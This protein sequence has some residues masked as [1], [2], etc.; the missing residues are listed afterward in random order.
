MIIFIL[1]VYIAIDGSDSVLFSLRQ[2]NE[3]GFVFISRIINNKGRCPNG[4]YIYARFMSLGVDVKPD[5]GNVQMISSTFKPIEFTASEPIDD[6][7]TYRSI[8]SDGMFAPI[9]G[10]AVSPNCKRLVWQTFR[11]TPPKKAH[12][13]DWS[14]ITVGVP[15]M[16][17]FIGNIDGSDLKEITVADWNFQYP[18]F[19]VNTNKRDIILNGNYDDTG[20]YLSSFEAFDMNDNKKVKVLSE[21]DAV[22]AINP[23]TFETISVPFENLKKP[24]FKE[25]MDYLR[26]LED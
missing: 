19:W 8:I 18:S 16:R 14:L 5:D 25:I 3:N 22:L 7:I 2:A 21:T 26:S 15:D 24:E 17:T 6:A 1:A 10:F 4:K 23:D 9:T 12:L 20:N 11:G 13:I